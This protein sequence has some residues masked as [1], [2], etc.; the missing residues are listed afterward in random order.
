MIVWITE[1]KPKHQRLLVNPAV[2]KIDGFEMYHCNI[3]DDRGRGVIMYVRNLFESSPMLALNSDFQE[4]VWAEIQLNKND[5]LLVDV[6]YRSPGN[7]D[8]NIL[9]LNGLIREAVQSK[10]FHFILLGDHSVLIFDYICYAQMKDHKLARFYYEKG[11]YRNIA[12]H[13]DQCNWDE[14]LGP[15]DI[16]A[17]WTHFKQYIQAVA[18]QYIP[19]RMVGRHRRKI[20]FDKALIKKIKKNIHC[21]NVAWKRE[22]VKGTPTTAGTEIKCV[23]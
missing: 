19:H 13:M 17:Q 12:V 20:P 4:S 16:D 10:H 9:Y 22:M 11:D 3:G 23:L 2:L 5:S 6:V 7:T 21:G 15:G 14:V 1:V 18:D 8:Q